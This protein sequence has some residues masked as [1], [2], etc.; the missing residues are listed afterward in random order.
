MTSLDEAV[1]LTLRARSRASAQRSVLVGI[2]GIDA[3]GKG[4]VSGKMVAELRRRNLNAV[5]L[6][7]DD[8]LNLPE[9]RFG[10]SNQAWH[11]YNHAVRFEEMFD[12]FVLPLK[13]QRSYGVVADVAEETATAYSKRTYDFESVDVIVLEG[14][15]LLKAAYR[16]YFDLSF[17]LDCTFETASDRALSRRQEAFTLEETVR[18]YNTIYFPAQRIH[19]LRDDP[20][21]GGY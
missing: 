3:S 12:Q 11:F 16:D 7:V 13:M 2:S 20:P 19:F 6:H 17:W 10:P 1:K 21:I 15:F 4:Y 14:I 18:I 8:W 9:K 5:G